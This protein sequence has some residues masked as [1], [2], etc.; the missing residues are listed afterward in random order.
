MDKDYL[1]QSEI[2]NYRITIRRDDYAECPTR[3]WSFLGHFIWKFYDGPRMR[4]SSNSDTNELS[5]NPHSLEDA[6]RDLVCKYV[7]QKEIIKYINSTSCNDLFFKYDKSSNIWELFSCDARSG[8]KKSEWSLLDLTPEEYHGEDYSDCIC[9]N[10][11]EEDFKYLLEKHQKE[12]AFIEFSSTG[13]YQGCYAEGIAYCDIKRFERLCGTNTKNW[14]KRAVEYMEAESNILYKWMWG[15]VIRW[16]L[17]KKVAYT[18]IY[19][20]SEKEDIHTYEWEFVDSC[21]G[22]Y[23]EPDELINKVIIENNLT[24]KSVA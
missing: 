12:I 5:C 1:E 22:Y 7:S 13:H 6:L 24:P 19:D 10:L 23:C 11:G 18:K 20:N 9:E 15:D 2:N 21:D 8:K 17:E 14:R 16:T 3:D 4:L